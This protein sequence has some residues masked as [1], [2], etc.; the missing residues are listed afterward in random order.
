M[1]TV[2]IAG[3]GVGRDSPTYVIAEIGSNHDGSLDKACTMIGVAA[4]C[5]ADAVKFQSLRYDKV[6]L[7]SAYSAEFKAF[8][9]K[10]EL[11]E[12][13]YPHLAD[14][15]ADAGVHWFS[16]VTY[17]EAVDD[18]VAHGAA[19][20][21]IASAQFDLYPE[22]VAHAARTGLPLIMSTGLA[23]I[24]GIERT[25]QLVADVGNEQVVLLHC[26]SEYP[27]PPEATN[28]R[29][30]RS[31]AR[32]FGRL[33]G[34]SDH[35]LGIEAP[36]AAVAL[37]AVAL[38]KHF[39]LD[40]RGEGPDHHFATEPRD[41]KRMVESIRTVEQARGD[42]VVRP[43]STAANAFKTSIE[44][45]WVT[46]ESISQGEPFDRSKLELRRLPGGIPQRDIDT[47]ERAVAVRDIPAHEPVQWSDLRFEAGDV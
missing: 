24:A 3:R 37:G 25:L 32:L 5:G 31:Y 46:V 44:Y 45:K 30:M 29:I 4:K 10:L 22:L 42:G 12:G 28:L 36:I 43:L 23:D 2:N 21:K 16:S 41:F 47:L 39:T 7:A 9:R 38:E 13:W 1:D 34:Y 6:N 15:A 27:T 35:T 26:V 14:A 11:P 18:L 20:I 17:L 8:F 40:R 19:A 33:V